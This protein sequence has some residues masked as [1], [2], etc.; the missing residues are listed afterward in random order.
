MTEVTAFGGDALEPFR[1]PVIDHPDGRVLVDAVVPPVGRGVPDIDRLPDG[2]PAR[3]RV[4]VD[5][6]VAAPDEEPSA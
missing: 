2:A 6:T 4:R 5:V 3:R 1:L